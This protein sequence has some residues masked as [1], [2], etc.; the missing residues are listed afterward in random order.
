V[1][2]GAGAASAFFR[3]TATVAL[4]DCELTSKGG[5]GLPSAPQ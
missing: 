3:D 1:A 5:V 4:V 2:L